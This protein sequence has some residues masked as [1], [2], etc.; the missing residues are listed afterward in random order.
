MK[1]VLFIPVCIILFLVACSKHGANNETINNQVPAFT[2]N[3]ITNATFT[4]TVTSVGLPLTVVYNDSAQEMVS[5]CLSTLPD[6]I[7]IDSSWATAG[8]PT[9]STTLTFY[10][11]TSFGATPG[12]YNMVLSATGTKTGTKTFPFSLTVKTQPS[13]ATTVTGSY[14]NC[15]SC[16]S[17]ENFTDSVYADTGVTNKIWFINFDNLGVP[18]YGILNCKTDSIA[19]PTQTSGNYT[20]SGM[21][22]FASQ[23]IYIGQLLV[24]TD[25]C[26]VLD[27][28]INKHQICL[29]DKKK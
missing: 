1:K 7:T 25:S 12:T 2:V 24:N 5:L 14:L 26:T 15:S 3:G 22:F 23:Y 16:S 13:C 8:Y 10:D 19:I 6:G 9:F 4:G 27:E 20:F 11:T 21:G 18:V 29:T 17:A 28:T